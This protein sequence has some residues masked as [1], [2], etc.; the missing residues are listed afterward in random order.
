MKTAL[1][2]TSGKS[3]DYV[4]VL[5]E[6]CKGRFV[7]NDGWNFSTM[8]NY[9]SGTVKISC[10]KLKNEKIVEKAPFHEKEIPYDNKAEH[11]ANKLGYEFGA[12]AFMLA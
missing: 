11:V 8:T 2:H 12:L 3:F 9:S 4:A 5:Q 10:V 1:T 7:T 6:N